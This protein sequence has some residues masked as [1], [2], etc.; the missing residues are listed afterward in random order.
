[1]FASAPRHASVFR[2]TCSTLCLSYKIVLDAKIP[3][4]S[5]SSHN[6]VQLIYMWKC[7]L[8]AKNE[9]IS[10]S[11]V[12]ELIGCIRLFVKIDEPSHY[13]SASTPCA[14]NIVE[15][16]GVSPVRTRALVHAHAH[17][18]NVPVRKLMVSNE[19]HKFKSTLHFRIGDTQ[20]N[21]TSC[22]HILGR[23]QIRI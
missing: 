23:S 11:N 20:V 14:K 6:H 13:T 15:W 21:G 17:A 1:M 18:V 19:K 2:S 12:G 9:S 16:F 8:A 3:Q 4:A 10:Y 5:T 7:Q 22:Q